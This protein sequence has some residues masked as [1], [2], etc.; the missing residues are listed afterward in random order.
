[1]ERRAHL[2]YPLLRDRLKTY[3]F[4]LMGGD[5]LALDMH[6]LRIVEVM[7]L[8]ADD[9]GFR[10]L[11]V[12]LSTDVSGKVSF[13]TGDPVIDELERASRESLANGGDGV[14]EWLRLNPP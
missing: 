7:L 3:Q 2:S 8:L 6:P 12:G 1:M 9:K 14:P 5:A 10:E 11:A 4:K 13:V